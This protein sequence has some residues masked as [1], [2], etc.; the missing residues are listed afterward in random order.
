[1]TNK[2]TKKDVI[3]MMM[4]DEVI[5]SNSTYMEFLSHEMELLSKKR[6]RK[7]DE[8]KLAENEVIKAAILDVLADF[9][10]TITEISKKDERLAPYSTQRIC[11]VVGSMDNVVRTIG[12]GGKGIYSLS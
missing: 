11:S 4:A 8:N 3:N 12:K 6:T 10:G 1:M 7:V 2:I 5:A 9:S